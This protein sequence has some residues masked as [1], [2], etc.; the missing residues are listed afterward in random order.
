MPY[1]FLA[2]L[3]LLLFPIAGSSGETG[4]EETFTLSEA[5]Q[6][7]F[8]NNPS[9]READLT[10]SSTLAE[11]RRTQADFFVKASAHYSLTNLQ[12]APYQQI[13]GNRMQVGDRDVHHW[14][15]TLT[16]PLFTGFAITSRYQMARISAEI[17]ALEKE[18]TLL[19]VSQAVKTAWFTSLLADKTEKVATNTVTALTAHEKDA[20]GFFK[21]GVIPHN[22]LLKS[23]VALANAVQEKE[24]AH[25]GT[26][27]ALAR[28]YTLIG[29]DINSVRI[30]EDTESISPQPQDLPNLMT[31]AVNNSPV[32][33]SYRLGLENLDQAITLAKSPYYPEIAL[34]GK[35]EQNGNDFGAETNN[36]SNEHNA[37]VAVSAKW[38]FFE[39]G[40]TGAD[41]EKQS[42]A[43]RALKEKMKGVEDQI[44]LETKSAFFDLH[45]AGN[46]IGTAREGLEQA[47]ENARITDLQYRNQVTTSTEVLDSLTFL[48]QAEGNY[49]RA[50]YGYMVALANLERAVGRREHDSAGKLPVEKARILQ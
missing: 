24:R 15:V 2:L 13:S 22:D 28:L 45:V 36:Y 26:Q 34:S 9:L 17:K 32:L 27:I 19:D 10:H 16:Q 4:P 50:L 47:R 18:R 48:S 31:E 5:L 6:T 42:L 14:D 29:I 41:V 11:V 25:A 7:A 37:L 21:H 12:D 38:D 40:K 33:A 1:L 30:Q 20:E 35:Y 39:W 43:Q 8:V 3:L 49:Y 23:K 44:R 46:N